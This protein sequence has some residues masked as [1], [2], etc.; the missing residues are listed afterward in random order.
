MPQSLTKILIHT[1]FSTKDRRPFLRDPGLRAEMHNM[2]GGTAKKLDCIPIIVGGPED[3]A[4][5]LTTLAKKIE[6]ADFVKEVKRV[7]S[8]WGKERDAALSDFYWQA[9]YGCFS[10]GQSQIEDVCEY[11]A[12]QEEHHRRLSFKD[13]FRKLLEKYELEHDERYV[14]D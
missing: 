9:G 7:T 12:N 4:H 11:I 10:I 5:L 6:V 2:L 13:E 14:W 8:I 3:H 1:V